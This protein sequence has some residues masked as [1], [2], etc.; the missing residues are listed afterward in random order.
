MNPTLDN[1]S[2]VLRN[3]NIVLGVFS[4]LA[5]I[6]IAQVINIGVVKGEHYRELGKRQSVKAIAIE[7][8][9]GKIIAD[10][11]ELLATSMPFY[12]VYFDPTASRQYV[13]EMK[14]KDPRFMKKVGDIFAKNIDSLS[15]CISK[16]L[17]PNLTPI[18]VKQWL[19]RK[20]NQNERFLC[21]A[22]G[23]SH[24]KMKQV[25]EFPLF[26]LGRNKSGIIFERKFKRIRPY[27]DLA[28]RTVGY[29]RDNAPSIGLEA[30]YDDELKGEEGNRMVQFISKT[31]YV[32][33]NDLTEIE[34][35]NGNDV[36]TTI[37]VQIQDIAQEALQQAL[38]YHNAAYGTA[39]VMEV[40]TGAVKAMA[41]LKKD[42]DQYHEAYNYAVGLSVEPGSTFK[43]ASVMAILEDHKMSLEK[44]IDVNYGKAVICGREMKDA[45]AHSHKTLTLRQSFEL[46]SNVGIAKAVVDAFGNSREDIFRFVDLIRQFHLGEITGVDIP[47]EAKPLIKT[48]YNLKQLWSRTSL[49]WMAHGYETRLTPLQML[50]FYNAV[51]NNGKMMQ[52]RLVSGIWSHGV[53]I[54]SF[55]PRVLKE[56]IASSTTIHQARRLLEGVVTNGTAKKY[57]NEMYSFAGKTGTASMDYG[58]VKRGRYRASFIGYFPA[59]NPVYSICVMITE[60]KEHG[61]HGAEVALP[62]F[63]S[64]ADKILSFDPKFFRTYTPG[65]D[66]TAFSNQLPSGEIGV[67]GDYLSI[68]NR[69]DIPVYLKGK[70]TDYVVTDRRESDVN[71]IP[72]AS[73]ENQVPDVKGM[74]LRDAVYALEATG[75]KVN[76]EGYGRVSY[77]DIAPGTKVAGQTVLIKLQ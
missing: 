11:G 65:D 54:K 50:T 46:S 23:I 45:E 73:N 67:G 36:M 20:R 24:I 16:Y 70:T 40:K 14:E 56:S 1:K 58:G 52:P 41:N 77:Q 76:I 13:N 49:P 42:G 10:N 6:I 2:E 60:P 39:I 25:K 31:K 8:D 68:F 44:E 22:K 15:Y 69:L 3:S 71:L 63:R 29:N 47:G 17:I 57:R 48:P 74:G 59:D 72:I 53:Q 26:R 4:I 34:P 12:D 64:I 38:E 33:I 5:V 18:E 7:A 19:V 62:V 43:L 51:A 55:P 66:V 28:L 37:N 30:A 21:L 9:R 61:Y 27:G 35:E 32:P 75:L